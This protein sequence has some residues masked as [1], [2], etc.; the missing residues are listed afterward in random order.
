MNTSIANK[1]YKL[2]TIFGV[3]L[4]V[5]A[6]ILFYQTSTV[7]DQSHQIMD[8]KLPLLVHAKDLQMSVVQVQQW[9]TDISATRGLDGLNDGFE[10]AQENADLF[11]QIIEQMSVLDPS[12]SNE[13]R[14]LVSTFKDYHATGIMMAK[15]Y[16]ARGPAGGNP[17]MAQFD[18][19][20]EA[21]NNRVDSM[22]ERIKLQ[23]DNSLRQ[24]L[25]SAKQTMWT[26]IITF[27]AFAVFILL[28]MRFTK[29]GLVAPLHNLRDTVKDMA[30]RDHDQIRPVQI[31]RSCGDEICQTFDALNSLINKLQAKA[32]EEAASASEN[33]R[34]KKA[35]DVC[36]ANVMVADADLN[37]IYHNDALKEMMETAAE[38]I[39]T[40]LP[41]FDHNN[42]IGSNIDKF[43]VEPQ[44]QRGMLEKLTSPFDTQINVGGRTM[45]LM[46][47]PV[48]DQGVRIGFVVEWEDITQERLIEDQIQTL[49]SAAAHGDLSNRIDISDKSGF[50]A[51]LATELNDLMQVTDQA[52]KD[53]VVMFGNMSQ[54]DLTQRMDS[55]Y[56]G[57]FGQLASDANQ[58][59][60][61]LTAVVMELNSSSMNVSTSANELASANKSLQGR[62]ESQAAG[63]DQTASSMEEIT[64]TVQQTSDNANLVATEINQASATAQEGEQSVKS[65]VEAMDS[66]QEASEK[67]A[68]I[69]GVIDEIAFQTN[70]LALNA[71]V[72]A[73]RAGESGKSFAVVASEVRSLA[74]RSASAAGDIK[75]LINDSVQRVNVGVERV[76]RSGEVI[77][78]L[79]GSMNNVKGLVDTVSTAA[80]EQS[81]GIYQVNKT[82]SHLDDATQQNSALVEEL[83]A[84]ASDLATQAGEVKS[85][86]SFFKTS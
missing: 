18:A 43:H 61:K 44:K 70:L 30:T 23:T 78:E 50:F 47:T 60:D 15:A 80:Q 24:E 84:T 35:L 77:E 41:D 82:I 32:A 85:A 74:Q 56:Q 5:Q 67:I 7:S 46:I 66:I 33:E 25:D 45:N 37:I 40:H 75:R 73:A 28:A 57:V 52:L 11:H 10:V 71:S 53:M 9:L 39:R 16:V 38:A 48:L 68:K 13:Y 8:R 65:V 42:L 63:L 51:R 22:L 72:E 17:M 58:M 29:S 55:T 83:S 49:V 4:V 69:I 20:A 64:A 3:L 26:V 36:H 76:G 62:T 59:V 31:D 54:G 81:A 79:I 19:A 6:A 34:I 27:I 2:L 14:E 1:V 21:I 86:L 12:H